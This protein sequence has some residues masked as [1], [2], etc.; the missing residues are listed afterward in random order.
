MKADIKTLKIGEAEKAAEENVNGEEEPD[1]HTAKE[2]PEE[3]KVVEEKELESSEA[4]EEIVEKEDLDI[5]AVE[6][7]IIGEKLLSSK[8]LEGLNQR[9]LYLEV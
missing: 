2:E 6:E 7:D 1:T 5:A 8:F 4:E 9:P 3:K